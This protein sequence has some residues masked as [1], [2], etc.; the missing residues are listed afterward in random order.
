MK[1]Y[2]K[3]III[4]AVIIIAIAAFSNYR[5]AKSAP[6]WRVDSPSSG[7][8]REVVT[9]TGSLNPYVLVNVGTEVSGKIERLYK[10]FNDTVKKGELLAKLDT[11]ILMTSLEVS[12]GDLAKA[13]TAMQE[14]K[15]DYDL[16]AELAEQEMSSE[17]ELAKARFKYQTAQQNVANAQLSLQ[18]AEKNLANAHI[19]SPINGVIV[20]RD[21]D[22]GQTVAASLNSPTLFVIANNLERMQITAKVDEADIGKIKLGLPVEFN[23]DA[24]PRESFSGTVQQ[25]RLNPTTESNVVTY[26]VIID[27]VNPDR[28]LLP[29]MTTNVTFIIRA[30]Q[31][32]LR[33]PE[34]A[35]R[36]RPSKEIWEL[37]D[38]KW[39]DE[40]LTAG[41]K[42][43]QEMM[44]GGAPPESGQKRPASQRP[45]S[46][47]RM[48]AETESRIAVVW[49]L[50]GDVPSPVAV[51]TG[52][53]DGAYVELLEGIAEDDVLVTGVIYND[54]KQAA[55]NSGMPM[56]RF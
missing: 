3:Y 55:A 13:T 22:E 1:K 51:R 33:L 52:V 14:A 50:K 48:K 43:M 38:L 18:R 29:G 46:G 24:Y 15:L 53:S 2:I 28:K 35:T 17:Y 41:R 40:L 45:Q 27:A 23:V 34:T 32:V 20:S 44:T 25:I 10:D 11:E 6:S 56:R 30:K 19:T 47:S 39:D 21:V 9:A 54:P 12:R 36:F 26:S 7:S 31:D 49:I 8:V 37:F 16:L 42:V 5:K 4:A